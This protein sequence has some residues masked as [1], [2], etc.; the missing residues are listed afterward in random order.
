MTYSLYHSWTP[1]PGAKIQQPGHHRATYWEH[2]KE[3]AS[4]ASHLVQVEPYVLS[5]HNINSDLP[6]VASSIKEYTLSKRGD[7]HIPK[8]F[9]KRAF[10]KEG[11]AGS[12]GYYIQYHAH[13]KDFPVEF[14]FLTL[15]WGTCKF[16]KTKGAYK[17]MTP[18]P[19]ELG[20][21]IPDDEK[22]DWSEWGP[23]DSTQDNDK[24]KSHPTFWW[25]S[26]QGEDDTPHEEITIPQTD[27]AQEHE[28]QLQ[29]ITECIPSLGGNIPSSSHA[30]F[31]LLSAA[32]SQTAT[33]APTHT[34]SIKTVQMLGG[35][36]L[37]VIYIGTQ[38][39]YEDVTYTVRKC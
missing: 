21:T 18:A 36:V 31:P 5:S 34:V 22:V 32:M 13:H 27:Q 2:L 33:F 7:W 29:S 28:D 9:L 19:K 26:D 38:K 3:Q 12:T 17:V 37:I 14:E 23:L 25:A 1:L 16:S 4:A 8:Q 24:D 11:L 15:T 20:L 6:N 30:K 35:F 39:G 10:W